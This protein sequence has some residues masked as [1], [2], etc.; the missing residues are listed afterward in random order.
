MR[1]ESLNRDSSKEFLSTVAVLGAVVFL[2]Q[3]AFSK[4][5]RRSILHRDQADVWDGTTDGLEAAHINHNRK[6]PN[7]NTTTNG[8]M[9]KTRN[10]YIDHWNTVGRNGLSLAANNAALRLIWAR[11]S[12]EERQGLTPPP[13][14]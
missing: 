12:D 10:H 6:D 1:P 3:F 7:Y 2:S 14:E 11:L 9:L 4:N 5:V 8:R 13:G